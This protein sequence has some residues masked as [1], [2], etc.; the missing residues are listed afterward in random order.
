MANGVCDI[1]AEQITTTVGF[2]SWQNSWDSEK[3]EQEI[4]WTE[5]ASTGNGNVDYP[6][7]IFTHC[8]NK[9]TP[10]GPVTSIAYLQMV[11]QNNILSLYYDE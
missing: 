1:T 11:Q 6:A 9:K 2:V 4:V 5:E 7:Q 8:L 3:C 10:K